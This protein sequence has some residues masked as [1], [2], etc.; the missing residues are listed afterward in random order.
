MK[1]WRKFRLR[2]SALFQKPQLDEDM[3]EEMRAH[4]EMRTR[5]NIEAGMSSDEARYAALRQFG[6]VESIKETC[7]EQRAVAWIENLLQDI[8]YG[9]RVLRKKPGFTCV[10][11]LTLA[12]GIGAN[13]SIFSVVNGVLLKPLPYD[14]PAKVVMVAEDQTGDGRG[15]T[16]VAGGVFTDWKEQSKSF[17]ALSVL[18]WTAMNLSGTDQPELVSGWQVSKDFLRILRVAPILGRD[19]APDEDQLGHDNKVV[20]LT[21]ELWRRRFGGDAGIVGRNIRVNGEPYTVIGILPPKALFNKQPQLLVPFVFGADEWY[22]SRGDQRF[23]VIARLKSGV[24]VEQANAE[25]K[26]IKQR[27]AKVYPKGKEKW[28]AVATPLQEEMTGNVRSTLLMLFG[29]VGFVL[30]IACANVANLLLAQAASR[31]KEM[32]VRAAVGAGRWRVIR[33]VVTESVLLAFIG[34]GLGVLLAVWATKIFSKLG[35]E[36]LPLTDAISLDGHVLAFSMLLSLGTGIAFGLAPALRV[37]APNLYDTLREG[38]RSSVSGIQNRI[39]AGLV[40]SEVALAIM[41][42]VGAG[43]LL[44]SFWRLWNTPAG[45]DPRGVLAMGIVLPDA[46]YPDGE[47]RALFLHQLFQ[48]IEAL[49]GVEAAGEVTTLPMEGG[50]LGSPVSVE[51]RVSQPELG[52][53][54]SYDFVAGQ[55]FRAMGIPLLRGRDFR[56]SDN[57]TNSPRTCIFN[58]ALVKK[59]FPNED[60]IGKRIRFWGD[61]WEVIGVVGSIRHWGLDNPASERIYLPQ[62]FCL[63]T[64]ELVIRTKIEPLS[65]ATTIPREILAVD[66]D[67]PVSTVHTLEQIVANS[68]A[69][70]R[71]T[72]TL[73]A[74]FA[75]VALGLAMIGLYGVM[76]YMVAQRTREIGIRMAL[77]AQGLDVLKLVVQNAMLLT[78]VGVGLGTIGCLALGRVLTSQLYDVKAADPAVLAGVASLLMVVALFA[79]WFP[80]RRAARVDPIIALRYE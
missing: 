51:G 2:V 38:G 14:T 10:A 37:S 11:V 32:A 50:S 74:V 18:S 15:K 35:Q 79:S 36:S 34:G 62:A 58:D 19:F 76:A 13:A 65:L 46:K 40:V 43:L 27:L 56:R 70:R 5:E 57:S 72:L 47:R 73:L 33:Q 30:L 64:G 31:Q 71:L 66:P 25:L 1:T 75:G 67:Q 52:Y 3:D 53:G 42:L 26:A 80:A 24:S 45:F 63:W 21:N 6:W 17:E 78:L 23:Q 16:A 9:A 55:Y 8:R 44:K 49:P 20:L 68:V 4:I 61:V 69:G 60:P 41:L 39:R 12:L 77:G 22:R 54:S 29:A 59:V 28:G 7:R 48:R